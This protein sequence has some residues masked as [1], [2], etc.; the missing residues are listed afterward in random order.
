MAPKDIK[1]RIH[2]FIATELLEGNAEGLGDATPLLELGIVDSMGIMRLTSFLEQEFR[3]SVPPTEL[4]AANFASI[5]ALAGLV[6]R[7]GG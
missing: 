1:T 4:S 2:A 7:L 6:E 3:L 5:E